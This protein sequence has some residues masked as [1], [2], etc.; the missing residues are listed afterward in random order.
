MN[1]FFARRQLGNAVQPAA[2]AQM[3]VRFLN[4]AAGDLFAVN[5]STVEDLCVPVDRL[6]GRMN[7]NAVERQPSY[8]SVQ[9][10]C[11]DTRIYNPVQSLVEPR[12]LRAAL[13]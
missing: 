5:A 10:S 2:G 1:W 12:E 4:A 7:H 13:G 11:N 8:G 3:I 6:I 9:I